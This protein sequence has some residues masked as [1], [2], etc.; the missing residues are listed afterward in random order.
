MFLPWPCIKMRM[1]VFIRQGNK[2]Q[3][4]GYH[5]SN[6]TLNQTFFWETITNYIFR[7]SQNH[8]FWLLPEYHYLILW[9]KSTWH[10]EDNIHKVM[11]SGLW[12]YCDPPCLAWHSHTGAWGSAA[13]RH[14]WGGWCEGHTWAPSLSA[15][16]WTTDTPPQQPWDY[17]L[18]NQILYDTSEIIYIFK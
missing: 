16:H 13:Q 12:P 11:D 15:G 10:S 3:W 18:Q 4:D 8:H 7:L 6:I 9:W 1:S 2:V 5:S 14:S 17:S